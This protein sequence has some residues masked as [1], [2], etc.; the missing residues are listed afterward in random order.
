MSTNQGC[1][2]CFTCQM[3]YNGAPNQPMIM[4]RLQRPGIN[5]N[6]NNNCNGNTCGNQ[7]NKPQKLNHLALWN[8]NRCNLRC[9]YCFVFERAATQPDIDMNDKVIDALPAFYEKYYDLEKQNFVY[10]FGGE[11]TVRFDLIQKI[12]EKMKQFYITWSMTSNMTL[13]TPDKAAWL[14]ERGFHAL[15]SIDGIR[16]G[17]VARKYQS[18][19]ESWEEAIRG[20]KLIRKYMISTPEIRATVMPSTIPYVYDSVCYFLEQGAEFMAYEP[21]YEIE[22]SKEDIDALMKQYVKVAEL[23]SHTRNRSF[24]FKPMNDVKTLLNSL[25]QP[26]RQDSWKNR[27]GLGKYGASVDTDGSVY[28]CHRFVCDHK[29]TTKIGDVFAG[30]DDAARTRIINEFTV[31]RPRNHDGIEKCKHCLYEHV[32]MGG[33][34]AMN[35]EKY[36]KAYMVPDSYCDIQHAMVKAL[37][38][39]VI[40]IG[41]SYIKKPTGMTKLQ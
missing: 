39:Y 30:I 40:D 19:K 2:N 12:Y 9:E 7:P 16:E 24:S 33:C 5:I 36:G 25:G 20:F 10:F 11:P 1:V 35:F 4:P 23:M 8:T 34:I 21:V 37:S 28:G 38:P 15:C 3:D 41:N 18:G 26:Q 27:C 22:W 6:G 32:C 29:P 13:L 17:D 14:G 31:E